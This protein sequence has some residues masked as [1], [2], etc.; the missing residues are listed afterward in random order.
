VFNL[1]PNGLNIENYTALNRQNGVGA[2][3]VSLVAS[4]IVAY[5]VR[6]VCCGRATP[7]VIDPKIFAM[8][9]TL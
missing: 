3:H 6:A 8:R 1:L 4:F 2:Y 7:L 5:L 9:T